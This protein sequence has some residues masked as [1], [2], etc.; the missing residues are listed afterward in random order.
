MATKKQRRRRQ[1]DRRHD[2]EYVYV[3][4]EGQEVEVD[5]ETAD[6]RSPK[7][8]D[9]KASGKR[10]QTR[11]RRSAEPPSWRRVGKRALIFAPLMLVVVYLLQGKHH[12]YPQLVKQTAILLV[13]FLPFSYLMDTMM[14][15][16]FRKR[17]GGRDGDTRTKQQ[18]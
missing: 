7:K 2:W 4:D 3:D 8:T 16:S 6:Q 17:L 15:R 1:K 9:A 11:G 18:R 5:E 13:F 14:Y 10:P 12:D